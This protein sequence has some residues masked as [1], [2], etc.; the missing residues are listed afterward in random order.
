MTFPGDAGGQRAT[1]SEQPAA[2]LE[3][4]D[5]DG[6]AG[7]SSG[8]AETNEL[9]RVLVAVSGCLAFPEER[10]REIV[11]PKGHAAYLRAY[12]LCDGRTPLRAIAKSV[13]V[14]QGNLAKVYAKWIDAG[15]A[16]RVG[17]KRAPLHLYALP[18]G[19]AR[20]EVR[21]ETKAGDAEPSARSA[22]RGRRGRSGGDA[23]VSGV[24]GNDAGSTAGDQLTLGE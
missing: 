3:L 4:Q 19:G 24:G 2:A 17:P 14:D 21:V 20:A 5:S 15:I 6:D 12:S 23:P 16:F 9:L 7:A 10:L 22:R 13:G 18:A 8:A 1:R 11:S